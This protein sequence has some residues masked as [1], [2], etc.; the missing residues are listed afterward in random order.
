MLNEY[1]VKYDGGILQ[2]IYSGQVLLE[3]LLH[4]C[5]LHDA[6]RRDIWREPK[7]LRDKLYGKLEE[8]KR[9]AAFVRAMDIFV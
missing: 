1:P 8:L 5:R 6:L 2:A 3:H 4:H 7:P 9:T